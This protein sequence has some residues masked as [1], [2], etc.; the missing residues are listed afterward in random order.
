MKIKE[1]ADDNNSISSTRWAFVTVIKF[2]IIVIALTIAAYIIG[3]FIDKPFDGNLISGVSLLLGVLT[4]IIT[5]S[6]ALQGFETKTDYKK[7]EPFPKKQPFFESED[8][9]K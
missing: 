6:K 9:G 8:D 3:H 4:S 2:D 5:A 1:L 7:E